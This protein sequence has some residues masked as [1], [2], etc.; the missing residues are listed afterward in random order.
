M[1]TVKYMQI[2]RQ[3][4]YTEL[5][6]IAHQ[7]GISVQELIL[8]VIIPDWIRTQEKKTDDLSVRQKHHYRSASVR[9]RFPAR[10]SEEPRGRDGSG[11]ESRPPRDP[12]YQYERGP[13]P[14]PCARLRIRFVLLSPKLLLR[15]SEWRW[16]RGLWLRFP[17]EI[18][19]KNLSQDSEHYRKPNRIADYSDSADPVRTV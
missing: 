15:R 9:D 18:L 2:L 16:H 17:L 12:T 6:R 10:L 19:F 4:I 1:P 11:L 3:R 8:A 7:K 13:K 14:Y 5:D